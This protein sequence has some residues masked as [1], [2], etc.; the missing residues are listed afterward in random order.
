[1]ASYL[2]RTVAVPKALTQ[3]APEE[4]S[5]TAQPLPSMLGPNP[6]VYD[7]VMQQRQLLLVA[8]TQRGPWAAARGTKQSA[9]RAAFVNFIL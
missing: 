7:A 4:T 5:M 6:L 8:L 3:V 1:M 2:D 9:K